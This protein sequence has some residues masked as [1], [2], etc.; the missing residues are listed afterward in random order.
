MHVIMIQTACISLL[1]DFFFIQISDEDL[2]NCL[3]I[4]H[5]FSSSHSIYFLQK[6]TKETSE[7]IEV[8]LVVVH[9]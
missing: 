4:S 6:P 2:H 8:S 7:G 9:T 5:H 1:S 3:F